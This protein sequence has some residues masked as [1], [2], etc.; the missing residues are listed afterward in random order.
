M[1]RVRIVAIYLIVLIALIA[2]TNSVLNH[3]KRFE[4]I[5]TY[6]IDFV[7]YEISRTLVA[8]KDELYDYQN[9]L[10]V[11][12]HDKNRIFRKPVLSYQEQFPKIKENMEY[13]EKLLKKRIFAE[14]FTQ[15]LHQNYHTLQKVSRISSLT[16]TILAFWTLGIAKFWAI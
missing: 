9:T 16:H 3:K 7:F 4:V 6:D 8:A 2:I 12:Y 1:T 13:L 11:L 14:D 15:R 5:F 10:E